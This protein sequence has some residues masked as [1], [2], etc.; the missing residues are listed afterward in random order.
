[1]EILLERIKK[2]CKSRS[3]TV[4][5]LE[6]ELNLPNNTIYQWKKRVPGTDRLQSVAEYF[7][8]SI[9]YLLGRTDNKYMG[10]TE[11]QKDL[12]VDEALR[13]VRSHNGKEVSEND[14]EVLRRIANAY[15]DGNL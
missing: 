6:G 11:E 8:V 9:D 1:M 15:L 12:T 7:H 4:S 14:I 2:L 3:M 5:Q 10:M 13:L